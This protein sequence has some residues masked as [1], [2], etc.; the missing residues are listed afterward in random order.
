MSSDALDGLRR[1][2]PEWRPWL[3]LLE[4]ARAAAGDTAWNHAVAWEPRAPRDDRPALAE[5]AITVDRR[6]ADRWW[7]RLLSAAEG[8]AAALARAPADAIEVLDAAVS[9]D[10]PRL[11]ALAA[12]AG[13]RVDAMRAVAGLAVMPILHACRRRVVRASWQRGCCPVCG[14]W[15]TLAEARGLERS[16]HGRCARCGSDWLMPWLQCPFCGN[17]DHTRL[18]ALVPEATGEARKVEACAVCHGYLKTVMT[19]SP[20]PPADV[21]VL[22]LVTVDLDVAALSEG[23][24]RP[25]RAETPLDARVVAGARRGML[26]WLG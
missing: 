9:D 18:H 5:A 23:Y 17:D 20:T 11:E 2:H 12:G 19:L 15:P 4:P 8:P 25:A 26:A 13:V 7:R 21:A 22:D 14:A 6:A 3:A 1:D 24:T 10:G 16:R